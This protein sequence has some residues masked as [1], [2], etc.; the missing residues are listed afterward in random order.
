MGQT[1]ITSVQIPRTEKVT[2]FAGYFSYTESSIIWLF[3]NHKCS[4]AKGFIVRAVVT[5]SLTE[6]QFFLKECLS[7]MIW[8]LGKE[9]MSGGSQGMWLYPWLIFNVTSTHQI[10]WADQGSL[11]AQC[12]VT[13]DWLALLDTG[14]Q[15]NPGP[16]SLLT[17][18]S[19]MF[20][21]TEFLSRSPHETY[22]AQYPPMTRHI[23]LYQSYCDIS[24]EQLLFRLSPRTS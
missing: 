13:G 19:Y 7:R 24:P 8:G 10:T 16:L 20:L 5:N 18:N 4:Q 23:W 11:T 9:N 12:E 6:S 14:S 1:Y 21:V 17:V 2:L 22:C 3:P 15:Q